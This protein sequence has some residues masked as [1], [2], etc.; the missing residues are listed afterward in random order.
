MEEVLVSMFDLDRQVVEAQGWEIV[1]TRPESL[2]DLIPLRIWVDDT[3]GD[4]IHKYCV[5][6]YAPST[7]MEQAGELLEKYQLCL[8]SNDE[9]SW[10]AVEHIFEGAPH[11][12]GKTW[13]EAV[14][15]AVVAIE[16]EVTKDA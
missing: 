14:C 16:K 5:D 2:P 4:H 9:G 8:L 1:E 7:N 15:R 10:H 6:D 12:E 3:E 13:M 11:G